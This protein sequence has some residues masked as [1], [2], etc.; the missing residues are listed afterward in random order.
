MSKDFM[1]SNENSLEDGTL[2]ARFWR[3]YRSYIDE[4]LRNGNRPRLLENLDLYTGTEYRQWSGDAVSALTSQGRPA[5]T[6]N[7]IQQVVDTV[8]GNLEQRPTDIQFQAVAPGEDEK[9]ATLQSL[10]DY[11]YERGNFEYQKLTLKRDGLIHTG[12]LQIYIDTSIDYRGNVGLRPVHPSHVLIDPW[13]QTGDI[14]DIRQVFRAEWMDAEQIK[15][16]YQ[17]KSEVVDELIERNRDIIETNTASIDKVADR[18]LEWYDQNG[19]RYRVIECCYMEDEDY[20]CVVS[21][22]SG[23][24]DEE[25]TEKLRGM[26]GEAK[27]T[28]KALLSETHEVIKMT[29]RI[30]KLFTF[31][32]AIDRNLVLEDCDYPLQLGCVPFLVFSYKNV[33]GYRLGLPDV[34]RD[35]QQALNKRESLISHILSQAGNNNW[36]IESDTFKNPDGITDFQDRQS[37]GGQVFEVQPGSL[38][39]MGIKPLERQPIPGD[40]MNATTS[41]MDMIYRLSS[42]VPA[43]QG[44]QEGSQE[45]GLMFESKQSQALVALDML[46]KQLKL[47]DQ[48][49]A[50]MYFKAAKQIYGGAPREI[51][52]SKNQRVI[53]LNERV[54]DED[55]GEVVI[56]NDV[57]AI[58]RFIVD[59]AEVRVGPGRRASELNKYSQMLPVISNPVIKAMLENQVVTLSEVS[60]EF[61][62]LADKATKAYIENQLAQMSAGT[63]NAD[64]G[65]A[66]AEQLIQQVKSGAP[67]QGSAPGGAPPSP[68]GAPGGLPPEL[69]AMLGG[70]APPQGGALPAPG[71]MNPSGDGSAASVPGAGTGA[72]G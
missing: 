68:G 17:L 69:M 53:K 47:L 45:S 21:L 51:V 24:E 55:R 70:G 4:D 72:M 33:Y 40:L 20:D 22:D 7:L 14:R 52:D 8:L 64:A 36:L 30:C 38:E 27:A 3:K 61:K 62:G 43:M 71:P 66:Q 56:R 28:Y 39:R 48:V 49:F 10:Y 37:L 44:R 6:F 19:L 2:V 26:K 1:D 18:S 32:P 11:D 31:C 58:D 29:K 63:A 16:V 59:I 60:D 12:V 5:L 65:K 34:L 42:V 13:W 23:E 25:A 15:A 46:S 67:P 54:W 35:A 41:V 9:V 50:D 57:N